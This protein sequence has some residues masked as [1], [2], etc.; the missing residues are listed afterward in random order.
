MA[1]LTIGMT[2]GNALFQAAGEVGKKELI[3]E[4][5]TSMLGVLEQQPDLCAFIDTPVIS[6]RE[7]KDV[8]A[9]IFRGRISEE[10]LNFLFVMIDKGR[11][12][13]FARAI[14]V[15]KDLYNEEE[16]FSYGKIFSVKPLSS[17][18]LQKFE[19][20]TGELLQQNVKLENELDTSLIGGVKILIDGKVIDASIRKR[21]ED[22]N[23]TII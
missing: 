8:L 10:L 15:Y 5:A 13:H 17:D 9:S 18:R 16:G 3:L 1:E 21:L 11:T 4:E 7:K 14:K 20:E 22:L 6:I 12:R 19:A 23:N 2:Y